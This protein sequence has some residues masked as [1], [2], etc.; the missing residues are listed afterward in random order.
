MSVMRKMEEVEE[1]SVNVAGVGLREQIVFFKSGELR[2]AGKLLLPDTTY[3]VPGA[4]L[5][6]GL[7]SCYK[8]LEPS[9]QILASQGIAVLIFDFRGHGDSEGILDG[10]VVA[11][12]VNA[13][14]FLSELPEVDQERIAIVGHSLGAVAA[15]LASYQITPRVLVALSCPPEIPVSWLVSPIAVACHIWKRLDG[16]RRNADWQALIKTL[17]GMRLSLALRQLA[18]CPKLFVHCRGDR[19][20]PYRLASKLYEKAGQ[21]KE[22]LL[23][24]GGFHSA[25]LHLGSLRR[26]W[27]SWAATTLVN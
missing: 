15:I 27:T 1:T 18:D 22:L 5:C 8:A 3:P 12:V 16:S 4:I 13:W 25:P 9:A 26:R 20:T 23:F 7:T 21:P 2:L 14:H 24:E 6:H 10:N 11:D 17:T 19:V